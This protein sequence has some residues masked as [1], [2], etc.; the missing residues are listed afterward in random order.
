MQRF[1][2]SCSTPSGDTKEGCLS[3]AFTLSGSANRSS[4]RLGK[5]MSL[6]LSGVYTTWLVYEII[7]CCRGKNIVGS[8]CSFGGFCQFDRYIVTAVQE[9]CERVKDGFQLVGN[10]LHSKLVSKLI[11]IDLPIFRD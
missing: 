1:L 5:R 10:Y 6:F 4:H 11:H 3:S 7:R 8:A 9:R 2:W